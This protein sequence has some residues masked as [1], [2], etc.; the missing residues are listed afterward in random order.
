MGMVSSRLYIC[1]VLYYFNS[2]RI[3]SATFCAS[4]SNETTWAKNLVEASSPA[5]E[6]GMLLVSSL[7]L[8]GCDISWRILAMSVLPS[9]ALRVVGLSM[10]G[11]LEIAVAEDDRTE[12][13]RTQGYTT[14]TKIQ[15]KRCGMFE[16]LTCKF[17]RCSGCTLFSA[18]YCSKACQEADW[19]NHKEECRNNPRARVRGTT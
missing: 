18:H 9:F 8:L 16:G 12:R 13:H 4:V 11:G 10:H 3:F 17:S 5:C 1:A 6:L 19:P 15:C 14:I 2:L 7:G